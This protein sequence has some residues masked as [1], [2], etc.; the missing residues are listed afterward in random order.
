MVAA[1]RIFSTARRTRRRASSS[2]PDPSSSSEL[3]E[4]VSVAT[5]RP[6]SLIRVGACKGTGG[7][8]C[9][10]AF[11][12]ARG[13]AFGGERNLFFGGSVDLGTESF[14]G[15]L[16]MVPPTFFDLTLRLIERALSASS[17]VLILADSQ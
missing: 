2:D 15:A 12:C 9:G 4:S 14:P 7:G 10:G 1:A 16:S 6:F 3:E 11:G 8:A 13:C 17:P 5:S